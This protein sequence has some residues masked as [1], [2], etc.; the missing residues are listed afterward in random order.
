MD[1]FADIMQHPRHQLCAH[2]PMPTVAR[3]AQF[4]AFAALTGY[5]EDIAEAT[6]LTDLYTAPSEDDL[7]ELDAAF[8]RLLEMLPERPTVT[9]TYFEPDAR[10]AGGAYCLYTGQLRHYDAAEDKLFFTDG[11]VLLRWAVCAIYL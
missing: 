1:E 11:T 5:D 8:G 6:R 3:A 4:S 9:L 2:T 10:K 7:A